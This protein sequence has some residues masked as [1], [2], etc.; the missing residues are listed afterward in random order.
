MADTPITKDILTRGKHY[1][2]ISLKFYMPQEPSEM[3]TESGKTVFL[4]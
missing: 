1:K 2:F 4:A 3:K